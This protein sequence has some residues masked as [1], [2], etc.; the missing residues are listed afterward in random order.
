VFVIPRPSL[1]ILNV[2]GTQVYVPFSTLFPGLCC[3]QLCPPPPPPPPPLFLPQ[4]VELPFVFP[5]TINFLSFYN[6]HACRYFSPP[7]NMLL[8]TLHLLL[9]I[10]SSFAAFLKAYRHVSCF[11]LTSVSL[12]YGFPSWYLSFCFPFFPF[13]ALCA[14]FFFQ[15]LCIN[16][17]ARPQCWRTSSMGVLQTLF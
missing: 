3:Y 16:T 14:S 15:L 6:R 8:L 12:P 1:L 7:Q 10:V 5:P 9:G 13:F 2:L 17:L 11:F 4:H